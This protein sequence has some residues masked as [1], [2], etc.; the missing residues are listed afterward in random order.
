VRHVAHVRK[1]N[2]IFSSKTLK[3]RDHVK[4]TGVDAMIMLQWILKHEGVRLWTGSCG[5]ELSPVAGSSEH[6]N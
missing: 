1:V 2:K 6:G 5:S 4:H 3:G